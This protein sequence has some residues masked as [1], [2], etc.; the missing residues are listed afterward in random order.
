MDC[1]RV[2]CLNQA[3]DWTVCAQCFLF[4]YCSEECLE[5]DWE[6]RHERE[7][8]GHLF[9][10]QDLVPV[11]QEYISKLGRGTYSEVKLVQHQNTKQYYA[12]KVIKKSLLAVSL[13][14]ATLFREISLHKSLVH[15]NIIRL[16]DQLEDNSRIYLVLEYASKSDLFHY[17]QSNKRI[18][19]SEACKIFVEVC[20]AVKH[21][22]DNGIIHRDIKPENILL[23]DN[24]QIKICDLGW[25]AYCDEPRKT[26]CGTLD[27]M[28]PEILEGLS[29]S[30]PSDI[31]SLG[32]LLYELL[33]GKA[34]FNEMSNKD[35]TNAVIN[36][37]YPINKNISIA[38]KK[39]IHK[40]LSYNPKNRPD[41]IEI[42]KNRWIQEN[43]KSN[44]NVGDK[45]FHKT[46]G[47]GTI[48]FI[49]GLVCRINFDRYSSEF[50]IPEMLKICKLMPNNPND[51]IA[52]V[53]KNAIGRD[54]SPIRN[55]DLKDKEWSLQESY[56][57]DSI[58]E[59]STLVDESALNDIN[60]INETK[61]KVGNMEKELMELQINL[62]IDD[63]DYRYRRK[64]SIGN[65]LL[66]L[67]GCVKRKN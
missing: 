65:V 5:D 4:R 32:I 39:L 61:I 62:E 28:S 15:D 20:L 24:N 36:K 67:V 50:V 45:Y 44:V 59:N 55:Y 56:L 23:S 3:L 57:N 35:K 22:H 46:H 33:H 13:P 16:Y 48:T 52:E 40:I 43:Y 7:C 54:I 63:S 66:G 26:F 41:I 1:K 42:L 27:Y 38:A 8:P 17:I 11:N 34:P 31:W 9:N 19:E 18:Q 25:S 64:N 60:E 49:K 58:I 51:S 21:M 12:L 47:I 2:G 37:N 10:L 30:F 14:V 29:Y 6:E 53:L